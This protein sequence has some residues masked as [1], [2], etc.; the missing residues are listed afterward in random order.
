MSQEASKLRERWIREGTWERYFR[1]DRSVLDIGCST[2]KIVPWARGWDLDLGDSDAQYLIGVPDESYDIVFSAHCL[3]HMRDPAEALRNWW[4]VLKPEGY[5]IFEVPDEDLYEQGI[6][7]PQFNQDHKYTYTISKE[8]SWSPVT[9]SVTRLLDTLPSR[10]VVSIR[11]VDKNY[12][13]TRTD[14]KDQTDM[15]AEAGI[16]AI[17][18]K[19][20]RQCEFVTALHRLTLCPSCG[21][22][23]LIMRGVTRER[24][25][26]IQCGACGFHGTVTIPLD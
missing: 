1:A 16:E 5:L 10:K 19:V 9:K 15:G 11:I 23:E 24:A 13:Y 7:P 2:D 4:R 26:E 18:Q 20:S 14:F 6:W 17:V 8:A 3:E 12:D 25:F 21:R 22:G